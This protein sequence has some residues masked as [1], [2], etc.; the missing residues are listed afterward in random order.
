[1]QQQPTRD[2]K[3]ELAVRRLLHSWGYRYRVDAQPLKSVRRRA[4]IV[5]RPVRVAVFIDGCFWH[6]CPDHGRRE[7]R[8]N[9]EFWA[10]KMQ[11]N[12]AR[13]QETDELLQDAG[14]LVIRVWE[15]EPPSEVAQRVAEAVGVRRALAAPKSWQN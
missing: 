10:S 5:F 11:R 7:H 14:W 9:A 13:D 3:P 8:L 4:D 1:M 15:H 6:G 2:T 12:R